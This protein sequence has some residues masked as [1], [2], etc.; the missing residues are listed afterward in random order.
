MEAGG[1]TPAVLN[2]ANEVAV[3][4]FLQERIHLLDIF[5]TVEECVHRLMPE[6]KKESTLDGIIAC[7]REARRLAA[8][9]IEKI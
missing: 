6:A 3:A 1:A 5:N 8:A 2:A 9:A 4:A 7:D